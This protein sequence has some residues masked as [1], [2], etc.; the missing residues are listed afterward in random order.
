ML[1]RFKEKTKKPVVASFQEVAASGAYYLSCAADRIVAHPTSVVGS[2]GVIFNTMEFTGAM[3]KL[4]V[5]AESIKSGP[6]KDMGS[7]FH[8]LTSEER[9]V[10]QAMVDEY[11]NRFVSV[12]RTNRPT[13]AD[14]VKMTTATDGRVFSGIQAQELGLVDETGMLPDAI[15]IARKLAKSPDATVVMYKRP[16]GFKGSIYAN[17]PTPE[18]SPN[19]MQLEIPGANSMLPTGFYY[20]WQ[21]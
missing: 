2:I 14:K 20:M 8:A 7:P 18:R 16:F 15:K 3:S 6:L 13:A 10:M 5:R 21:P 11:Y 19:V 9:A 1:R 4:G 12:V 17:G